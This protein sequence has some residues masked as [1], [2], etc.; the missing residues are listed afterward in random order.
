MQAKDAARPYLLLKSLIYLGYKEIYGIEYMLLTED[1]GH[2]IASG[3]L[4]NRACVDHIVYVVHIDNSSNE[5]NAV[6]KGYSSNS[7]G[8]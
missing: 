8:S 3:Y 5:G 4:E 1:S 6:H 2:K 7:T